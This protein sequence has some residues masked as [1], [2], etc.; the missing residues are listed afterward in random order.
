MVMASSDGERSA[1]RIGAMEYAAVDRSTK[2]DSTRRFGNS[3]ISLNGNAWRRGM[4]TF[5]VGIA[6][7]YN[8]LKYL[9]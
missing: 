3:G 7:R 2:R 9:E 4:R 5:P 8:S 6:L 1:C